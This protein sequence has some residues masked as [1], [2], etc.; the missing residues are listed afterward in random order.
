MIQKELNQKVNAAL[1]GLPKQQKIVFILRFFNDFKLEE[2]AKILKTSVGSVK[3]T[4]FNAVKKVK[5]SLKD[6]KN[7]Y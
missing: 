3:G 2:I 4:L 5:E 1:E 7:E 6:F